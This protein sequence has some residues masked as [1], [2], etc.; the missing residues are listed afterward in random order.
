MNGRIESIL[1]KSQIKFELLI[2][3]DKTIQYF[4]EKKIIISLYLVLH[5][6]HTLEQL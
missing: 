4:K 6:M 1:K 5:M 2:V 3:S